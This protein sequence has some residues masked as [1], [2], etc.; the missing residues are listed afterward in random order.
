M[1][2]LFIVLM[3]CLLLLSATSGC[4]N[5]GSRREYLFHLAF[6]A[7]APPAEAVPPYVVLEETR[8]VSG[9][10]YGPPPTTVL[11]RAQAFGCHESSLPCRIPSLWVAGFGIG[12]FTYVSVDE[13]RL[14]IFAPGYLITTVY[15]LGFFNHGPDDVMPDNEWD[16]PGTLRTVNDTSPGTYH[17]VGV[18]LAYTKAERGVVESTVTIKRL[19]LQKVWIIDASTF[20]AQVLSLCEAIDRR[21]L[22]RTDQPTRATILETINLQY[23][24]YRQALEARTNLHPVHKAEF[25]SKLEPLIQKVE[26]WAK[27]QK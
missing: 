19:P 27:A 14:T 1:R 3:P 8:N 18:P 7:N 16:G 21:Q 15:P 6:G 9:Y 23:A 24:S 11:R 20:E 25:V 17:D 13:Y 4:A 10:P 2:T 5:K 22:E 26:A 12:I